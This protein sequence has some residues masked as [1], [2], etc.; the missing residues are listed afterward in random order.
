M[1]NLNNLTVPKKGERLIVS[2]KVEGR[3][4][5]FGIALDALKMKY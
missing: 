2:K 3:P 1:R 4:F 5:C